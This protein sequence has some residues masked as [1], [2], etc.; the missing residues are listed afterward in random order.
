MVRR[1]KMMYSPFSFVMVVAYCTRIYIY[2]QA[3]CGRN[4]VL[5]YSNIHQAQCDL[6]TVLLYTQAQCG[7]NAVLL[8]T[9]PSVS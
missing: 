7:R 5:L 9:Q 2:T 6:H 4:A 1:D 8:Y 3:Q